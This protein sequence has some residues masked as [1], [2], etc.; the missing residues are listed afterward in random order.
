M[1]SKPPIRQVQAVVYSRSVTSFTGTMSLRKR[2]YSA[3]TSQHAGRGDEWAAALAYRREIR[4]ALPPPGVGPIIDI[5]CGQGQLV[6][7]LLE[8]GYTAEGVDVSPEQVEI[9][10]RSGLTQIARGDYRAVLRDRQG[11]FAAVTATDF[12]EHLV[13]EEVLETFDLVASALSPGGV[14]VARVPNAVSPLG[15]HIRHGD[16]THESWYTALSIRQLA[17]AAGFGDVVV[18]PCEPVVHSLA[19]ATRAGVWKLVSGFFKVALA[20]ETGMLHGHVV[21]QN[22]VFSARKP[23]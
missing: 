9:A 20:A 23:G 4:P 15:G 2:L 17:A 16:F 19:S 13:K 8:D 5:G 6:R 18:K 7:S 3:Y 10:R 22:L 12:L 1:T 11:K 14:F 21:T